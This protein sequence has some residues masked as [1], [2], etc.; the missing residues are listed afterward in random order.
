LRVSTVGRRLSARKK[1]EARKTDQPKNKGEALK[2]HTAAAR[3][4]KNR[5]G[6]EWKRCSLKEVL[7]LRKERQE[8]S[9]DRKE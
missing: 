3:S 4:R 1:E 6:F 2:R 7:T 8:R 5:R 9:R